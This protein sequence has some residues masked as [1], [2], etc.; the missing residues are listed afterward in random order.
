M[1][2]DIKVFFQYTYTIK[3]LEGAFEQKHL[4]DDINGN[5]Y[6]DYSPA[7]YDFPYPDS[8]EAF[9]EIRIKDLHAPV[10]YKLGISKTINSVSALAVELGNMR[11]NSKDINGLRSP[12]NNWIYETNSLKA[13][14]S[15]YPNDLSLKLF[16]KFSGEISSK[17]TPPTSSAIPTISRHIWQSPRCVATTSPQLSP[18]EPPA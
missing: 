8:V 3:P 17:N 15:H 13:S 1:R 12:I 4:F 14:F 18:K 9:S 10:G 5:G 2:E 16:D 7:Y 11:D 6:H